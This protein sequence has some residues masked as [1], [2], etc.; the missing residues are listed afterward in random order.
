M[1]FSYPITTA[2]DPVAESFPVIILF[3]RILSGCLSKED[4]AFIDAKSKEKTAPVDSG[5]FTTS[6]SVYYDGYYDPHYF[7]GSN[8]DNAPP[9]FHSDCTA[10]AILND[11][12]HSDDRDDDCE[13]EDERATAFSKTFVLISESSLSSSS[14]SETGSDAQNPPPPSVGVINVDDAF[15]AGSIT[16]ATYDI[17]NDSVNYD[18]WDDGWR[19]VVQPDAPTSPVATTS[20]T[21][22]TAVP[23]AASVPVL[24]AN[25]DDA[26][27]AGSITEA[28]YDIGNDSVNYNGWDDGWRD[29]VQP[30]APTSPVA[31]TS[32]TAATA[33]PVAASV[34][35]LDASLSVEERNP[36]DDDDDDE[37]EYVGCF[38][39]EGDD[40]DDWSIII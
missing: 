9:E 29:V 31:T 19:D 35:V 12:S 3:R 21:A 36:D 15:A 16:A 5:L 25:V 34:P 13:D 27:A 8:S 17:G 24:D 1:G 37:V 14:S 32:T 38:T 7:F 2:A 11:N 18:G 6:D 30:D 28:T 40:D 10:T 4:I 23:V 26:F 33:V 39:P 22:A 20:T